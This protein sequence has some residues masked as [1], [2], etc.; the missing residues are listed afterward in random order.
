H[1]IQGCS[2]SSE[3]VHGKHSLIRPREEVLELLRREGIDPDKEN[4]YQRPAKDSA[5]GRYLAARGS[6]LRDGIEKQWA[7]K[8][9]NLAKFRKSIEES[10]ELP[11]ELGIDLKLTPVAH[12]QYV[13]G[14][15]IG[16]LI[17]IG[18][19]RHVE[20]TRV[21]ENEKPFS[22]A[23]DMVLTMAPDV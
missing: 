17:R 15:A 14:Q 16:K 23:A 22:A 2:L 1:T 11:P 5:E 3:A 6:E 4:A 21:E 7:L 20:G 8:D 10:G 12:T 18:T 13:W 19:S 9:R